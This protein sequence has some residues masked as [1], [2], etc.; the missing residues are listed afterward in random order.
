MSSLEC[1][2]CGTD[3]PERFNNYTFPG[4][5][6][7]YCFECMY[8]TIFVSSIKE[9]INRWAIT[10]KCKCD[11]QSEYSMSLDKIELLLK[12]KSKIEEDAK[13]EEVKYHCREHDEEKK[14]FCR[15]CDKYICVHCRIDEHSKHDT[16]TVEKYREKYLMFLKNLPLTF[17]SL[18]EFFINFND[19][20]D[21]YKK[22][23][24]ENIKKTVDTIEEIIANLNAVK[25]EFLKRIRETFEKGLAQMQLMKMFYFNFY[26]DFSNINFYPDNKTSTK[27]STK[28]DIFFL[29]YL[30]KTKF[31]YD[32]LEMNYNKQ[33]FDQ[34]DCI[35]SQIEKFKTIS[36]DFYSVKL[37]FKD[38]PQG[39]K[40]VYRLFGHTATVN[41]LH[42]LK[43][44]TLVSG[45]MDYT[46]R[47]W[48]PFSK[49]DFKPFYAIEEMIGQVCTV[50]QLQ[51]R[52]ILT[53]SADNPSMKIWTCKANKDRKFEYEL[54]GTIQGHKR[55]I[56]S[57]I[58]LENEQIISAG[59]DA[60]IIVWNKND[61]TF[62]NNQVLAEHQ[63]VIYALCKIEGGFAS[64]AEDKAVKIWAPMQSSAD[65]YKC[66]Q[67]IVKHKGKVRALL[68]LK[69]KKLVS[70]GDDGTLKF[71]QKNKGQYEMV[72]DILGHRGDITCLIELKCGYVVS[73]SKDRTIRI[74]E[75]QG[76][77]AYSKKEVLRKHNQTVNSLVEL[78]ESY[79]ASAGGDGVIIIW[80][81]LAFIED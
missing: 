32:S 13:F 22:Q 47:F 55:A 61:R 34:L 72:Q 10:I 42:K 33:L 53:T 40:D 29:R 23:L 35:R 8:R 67:S 77:S 37:N 56:T 66:S 64:G 3:A 60:S 70:A 43:D 62:K 80:K 27:N 17:K 59:K 16:E 58:Q 14:Y 65:K 46:L 41:C 45:S 36:S 69:D 48:D 1:Y 38:I 39:F 57:I 19:S 76:G 9:F 50:L 71:Y 2:I 31:E 6:H 49:E 52:R 81:N 5:A 21:K 74:W 26:R 12:Y 20:T 7:S 75:K 15:S 73:C 28:N 24:D 78:N 18:E 51:D 11:K 79:F 30:A 68:Y 54:S 44:G 63:G 4:C 25:I